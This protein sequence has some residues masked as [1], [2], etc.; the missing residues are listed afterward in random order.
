M[1]EQKLYNLYFSLKLNEWWLPGLSAVVVSNALLWRSSTKWYTVNTIWK[2]SVFAYPKRERYY[3]SR[4]CF[5]IARQFRLS[6]ELYWQCDLARHFKTEPIETVVFSFGISEK[7]CVFKG[8]WQCTYHLVDERGI[9]GPDFVQRNTEYS[10]EEE[11]KQF[12]D[13]AG[14]SL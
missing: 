2:H 12:S 7:H 6:T 10:S 4:L 5:E 3:I 13:G 8:Y 9:N 14:V 1:K 11:A